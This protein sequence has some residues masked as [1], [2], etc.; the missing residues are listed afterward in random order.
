MDVVRLLLCAKRRYVPQ[1]PARLDHIRFSLSAEQQHAAL[2][3]YHLRPRR[4]AAIA[5][6]ASR[7]LGMVQE[8][9]LHLAGDAVRMPRT[10]L[11]RRGLPEQIGERTQKIV[12]LADGQS[13]AAE[14]TI[15]S[16]I[17]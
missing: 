14:R 12:A 8:L 9:P 3:H 15:S 5:R 13:I 7:A 16:E 4:S 2:D 6:L 11:I 10:A 17:S 1:L